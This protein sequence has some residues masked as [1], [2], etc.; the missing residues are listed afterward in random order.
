MV[1]KK[2]KSKR[3][4]LHKKYKIAA[5]VREHKRQERKSERA[6][7]HKKKKD[8]GIPNNW[9]FKEELLLQVEQSRLA[10]IDAQRQAQ[11]Q[12]KEDKKKAKLL[13]KQDRA[14]TSAISLVTPLSVEMQGKKDL[15]HS[16]QKADVVLVVLDARDPQGSRSLSLEDGLIAKGRKKVVLVLNKV[17]LISVETA[18]K[19]VNY[20]RRF[21]PT[22]PVRALNSKVADN[23]KKSRS[24]KSHKSLY[25]RQQAISGMRDNGE[26]QPLRVLLD[27]LSSKAENQLNIAV[28][29]YPNVGK[30]TLVNSLKR[31]LVTPVSS[32]SQS[33]KTVQEI[34]YNDKITLLDCPALDPDYS[35]ESAAILRHGIAGIFVEDPVPVVKNVIERGD[36]MNLMQTLQIPV[37][38]NH[39]E[40]LA[41]LAIKR[42]LLRKGGEPDI[43]MVARTFLQNMGKSVYNPSCLP[44]AKSKSR[45]ELPA[46]FQELELA[47]MSEAETLLYSSNP[48]GHKRVLV[49]KPAPISHAAGDTTEYDLVMGELPENDGLTSEDEDGDASMDEEEEEE[50]HDAED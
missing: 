50:M 39:E 3:L 42:N 16:V 43:L 6:N 49:F 23:A 10:E 34:Q 25:D 14:N 31:R 47:K 22:I 11:Q 5:K 2:G 40:F 38:R 27:E 33:T 15:K 4:S 8:P 44:P 36:A 48:T 9:P 17:D 41:K 20:L 30:S 37:F 1:K 29:G 46:W 28:V 21:H 45:F 35:D 26:V 24:D 12:R 19:W 18:Q 13:A 7:A 32:T